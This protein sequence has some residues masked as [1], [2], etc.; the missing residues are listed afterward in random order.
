[1]CIRDRSIAC[2]GFLAYGAFTVFVKLK[3][4]S[5]LKYLNKIYEEQ[6]TEQSLPEKS[7]DSDA[8]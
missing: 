3:R 6:S 2:F 7:D 4:K 8:Y 1:M 5:E